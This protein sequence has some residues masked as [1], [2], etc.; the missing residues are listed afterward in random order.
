MLIDRIRWLYS[1]S[2]TWAVIGLVALWAF[3]PQA[4]G[5]IEELDRVQIRRII[6]D[7]MDAFKKDDAHR[8][9]RHA[10][11]MIQERLGNAPQFLRL[12]REQ[13]VMVY[14]SASVIFLRQEEL[15]DAVYQ[16]VQISDEEGQV[17]IARYRMISSGKAGSR[18]WKIDGCEVQRSD[19][20]MT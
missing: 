12:V 11:P 4:V 10:S 19:G 6:E 5:A 1:Y 9:F 20:F 18:I 8:A 2:V 17:W 16:Y 7:Q 3:Q 14:R 13:Y 15:S